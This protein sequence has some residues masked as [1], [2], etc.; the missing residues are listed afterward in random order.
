M[1]LQ[2][3]Y[4]NQSCG[5]LLLIQAEEFVSIYSLCGIKLPGAAFSIHIQ[6]C[7]GDDIMSAIMLIGSLYGR[8]LYIFKAD[9]GKPSC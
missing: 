9:T 3:H 5:I 6:G 7:Y 2:F 1:K 4:R 8:E